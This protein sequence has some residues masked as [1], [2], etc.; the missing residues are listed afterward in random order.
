MTTNHTNDICFVFFLCYVHKR[1]K[2]R[3]F[4]LPVMLLIQETCVAQPTTGDA[5][6]QV[7]P[8]VSGDSADPRRRAILRGPHR[9]R[10]GIPR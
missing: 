3:P 9:T 1:P 6:R 4:I 2:S 8:F 10:T 7:G 5:Y